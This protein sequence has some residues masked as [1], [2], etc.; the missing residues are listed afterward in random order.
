V[1]KFAQGA[2]LGYCLG[3]KNKKHLQNIRHSIGLNVQ[4]MFNKN[5]I[6]QEKKGPTHLSIFTG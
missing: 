1:R 4:E 5:V 2:K 6:V 3:E